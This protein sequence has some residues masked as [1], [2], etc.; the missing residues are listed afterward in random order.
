MV[1]TEILSLHLPEALQLKIFEE[2]MT[3]GE[4]I[5]YVIV[6]KISRYFKVNVSLKKRN[7]KRLVVPRTPRVSLM[8]SQP[9]LAAIKKE[10]RKQ[11]LVSISATLQVLLAKLYGLPLDV[12]AARKRVGK[13]W[14]K[15]YNRQ[16][17]KK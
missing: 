12:L 14:R 15:R 5:P 8:L 2:A 6:K 9:L 17:Q 3:S 11:K 1:G 7:V 13:D 4:T 16:E 10:Q